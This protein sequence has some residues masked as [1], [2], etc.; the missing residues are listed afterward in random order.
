MAPARSGVRNSFYRALKA[1][2]TVT[3]E[4]NLSDILI[5]ENGTLTID[6]PVFRFYLDHLDFSRVRS[7]VNIRRIGYEYDVAVSFAGPDRPVVEEL[8]GEL[9][10]R[11]LE[12]FY[13]FDQQAALW[14]KDLRKELAKVYTQDA[15]FMVVCLS[16]NYPERDWPSFEFEIGKQAAAKRTEDYLLPLVVGD[17]RP[18]II[19]LPD[20]SVTSTSAVAP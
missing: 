20:Q 10:A 7:Q 8:K 18:A 4:N 6:D 11:G 14:G 5:Y 12:V 9:E 19:G 3:E 13:D 1:L 16:S 15:Q 17:E 2:P